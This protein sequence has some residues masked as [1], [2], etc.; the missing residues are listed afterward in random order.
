M[1][2]N[3]EIDRDHLKEEPVKSIPSLKDLLLIF[4]LTVLFLIGLG[5]VFLALKSV[6]PLDIEFLLLEAFLILP[7]VFYLKLNRYSL[8][9]AFRFRS[10]SFKSVII[11]VLFGLSLILLLNFLEGQLEFLPM[12]DWYRDMRYDLADNMMDTLIFKNTYEFIV[13]SIAVIFSAGLF[14]EIMFRGLLQQSLENRASPAAA[15]I[16]TS[17]LFSMLHPANVISIFI[18]AVVLGIITYATNSVFPAI[19]IHSMNNGISLY[20]LNMLEDIQFDPSAG[21]P[22]SI[23]VVLLSILVFVLGLRHFLSLSKKEETDHVIT[24]NP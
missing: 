18:L 8:I 4:L 6:F 10:I 1:N 17:L 13:L 7:A 11:S 3:I 5:G 23:N 19:I 2:N 21:I 20:S 15:I 12:P 14:E 9:G 24:E 16:V 22:I